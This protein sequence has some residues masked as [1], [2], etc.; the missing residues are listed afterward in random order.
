MSKVI[1]KTRKTFEILRVLKK[2]EVLEDAKKFLFK[3]VG[4]QN[5][6]EKLQKELRK[7]IKGDITNEKVEKFFEKNK[8]IEEQFESIQQE[9]I[10]TGIDIAF[11]IAMNIDKAEDDILNIIADLY[12]MSLTEVEGL[13]AGELIEK[14]KGVV[15]SPSFTSFLSSMTK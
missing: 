15:T 13:E 1:I 12:N 3:L 14:I 4:L 9:Q 10:Q 5:K 8:V 6:N 7:Q 2:L 11:L